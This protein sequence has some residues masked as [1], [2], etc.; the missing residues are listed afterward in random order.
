MI[1]TTRDVPD[2]RFHTRPTG[3]YFLIREHVGGNITLRQ[4]I[5]CSRDNRTGLQQVPGF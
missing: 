4:L 3:E 5:A 1:E 2:G